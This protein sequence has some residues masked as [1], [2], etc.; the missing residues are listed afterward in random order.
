MDPGRGAARRR[1]AI[2][3]LVRAPKLDWVLD[4]CLPCGG[5]AAPSP[6][7]LQMDLAL[8]HAVLPPREF[9]FRIELC[10]FLVTLCG[11]IGSPGCLRAS[12][13]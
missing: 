11:P 7:A 3:Q 1:P 12:D 6:P 5:T 9:S 13:Y 2:Q 4:P 8:A 10:S